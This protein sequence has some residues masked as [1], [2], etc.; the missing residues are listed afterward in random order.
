VI[1]IDMI[2]VTYESMEGVL[3]VVAGLSLV[4]RYIW[5]ND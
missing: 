3:L 2:H 5:G 1:A 4:D